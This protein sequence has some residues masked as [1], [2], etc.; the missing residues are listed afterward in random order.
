MKAQEPKHLALSALVL[1]E[2]P[3]QSKIVL[4]QVGSQAIGFICC[5]CSV[6]CVD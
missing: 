4:I 5:F 1:H 3:M 6:E 2:A